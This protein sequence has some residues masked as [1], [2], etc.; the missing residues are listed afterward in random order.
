MLMSILPTRNILTKVKNTAKLFNI[1]QKIF[2]NYI[3]TFNIEK[4]FFY[5]DNI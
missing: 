5:I 3:H 4:L 2:I 1:W